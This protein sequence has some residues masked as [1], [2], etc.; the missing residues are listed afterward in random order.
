MNAYVSQ[1]ERQVLPPSMISYP[2]HHA[3]ASY[4]RRFR[5]SALLGRVRAYFQQ[6]AVLAELDR[7]SDREL[8]DIGLS[9]ATIPTVFSHR[10]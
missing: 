8:A 7:L 6:R 1:E 10:G 2:E 3:E 9:R 5:L 4:R